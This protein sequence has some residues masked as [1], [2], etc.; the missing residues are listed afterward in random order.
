MEA[1]RAAPLERR[2]R[3]LLRAY[4]AWHRQENAD[5][6][7]GVLLSAARLYPFALIWG[8]FGPSNPAWGMTAWLA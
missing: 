3:R 8:G 6:M 4:P 7:L 2:Y 5:E 1:G